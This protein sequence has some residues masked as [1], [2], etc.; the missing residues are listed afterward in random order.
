MRKMTIAAPILLLT[1]LAT[2][3]VYAVSITLNSNNVMTLG[4]TGQVD[5][6]CPASSCQI[7]KVSWVMT[8]SAPYKV[9]KVDVTWTPAQSGDYDVYV[10]LYDNV[11]NVIAS[12]STSASGLT[13][14][15]ST[16][17]TVDVSVDADPASVYKVEI[18]IVQ[19]G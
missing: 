12:G 3:L 14:G 16:T 18:I 15:T 1:L 9:D 2:S 17:T 11:G 7:D 10:T 8:S 19:T 13:G 5:V 4:G 6:N